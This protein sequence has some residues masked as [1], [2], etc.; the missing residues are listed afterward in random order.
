M[1]REIYEIIVYAFFFTVL[2][3]AI[4]L[5]A[6]I[7]IDSE[8]SEPFKEELSENQRFIYAGDGWMHDLVQNQS[9]TMSEALKR[10]RNDNDNHYQ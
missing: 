9:V 8:D 1:S 2:F 5:L 3:G 10:A 7:I 4:V 6:T